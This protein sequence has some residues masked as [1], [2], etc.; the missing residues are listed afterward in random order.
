MALHG[1]VEGVSGNPCFESWRGCVGAGGHQAK[2]SNNQRYGK[3]HYDCDD[4]PEYERSHLF[5]SG[6]R[7]LIQG[8]SPSFFSQR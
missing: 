1:S 8:Q 7:I 4:D 2:L 5:S 6:I 3:H